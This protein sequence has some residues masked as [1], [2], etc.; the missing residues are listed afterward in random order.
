MIKSVLNTE[1]CVRQTE[2]LSAQSVVEC[3][4]PQSS[5][6]TEV[7]LTQPQLSVVSCEVADGRVNYSGKI[8]FTLV[9]SDEEGKLCRMQKGAEFSH[10]RDSVNLSPAQNG[11]CRLK[12]ERLTVKRDGSAFVVSAIISADI[13]VF[14]RAERSY[15]SS[16]DGA[17]LKMENISFPSRV[18]FSAESQAEDDFEADGVEDILAPQAKAI[19]NKVQCSVGEVEVSGDIYLSLFSMR[20]QSPVC[21]ERVIPFKRTIMCDDADGRFSSFA[22]AEVSDLNVSCSVNEERQ[23][24]NVSFSCNVSING[25]FISFSEGAAATDA[26]SE[27]EKVKLNIAEEEFSA[28]DGVKIYSE[29]VNALAATKNRL[30]YDCKFYAA[31]AP[32][33]ECSYNAQTGC[34]EGVARCTLVYGQNGEIKSCDVEAPFSVPLNGVA[35]DGQEVETEAFASGMAVRLR[36]EGEAEAEASLKI[37]AYVSSHKK[38][39]YLTEISSDGELELS[40]SAVS[41]YFPAAGDGLWD[42]AKKLNK[43]TDF[44]SSS[45]PSLTYPLAGNER[46]VVYR[47]K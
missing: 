10:Y 36:A 29:K 23:K 47:K 21:L 9:Y 45:N 37:C 22:R 31:C 34:A 20:R 8:I 38:I 5:G 39:S 7:I 24:C 11:V 46:I 19:V 28:I 25:Y 40:D 41:V 42:I 35:G 1:S 6:I 27:T 3:R 13:V 18:Y 2:R 32:S 43:P 30:G 4:F 12:C 44:I 26:F 14:A 16:A 33:A 15:I 17:Q